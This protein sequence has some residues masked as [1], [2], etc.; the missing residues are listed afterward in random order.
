MAAT[1]IDKELTL[2]VAAHGL[3]LGSD[4][5][6][7]STK[8]KKYNTTIKLGIELEIHHSTVIYYYK[9]RKKSRI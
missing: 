9:R 1:A 7:K 3:E 5:P 8:F 6:L 4:K 2:Y